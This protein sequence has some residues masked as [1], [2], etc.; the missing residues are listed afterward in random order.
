M[1]QGLGHVAIFDSCAR[2]C[3]IVAKIIIRSILVN[4]EIRIISK[5][6]FMI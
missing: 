1:V 4:I 6:Y 2:G 3:L 5:S